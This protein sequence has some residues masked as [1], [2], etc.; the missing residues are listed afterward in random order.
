MKHTEE[1][2]IGGRKS[3][4]RKMVKKMKITNYGI[5]QQRFPKM[6]ALWLNLKLVLYLQSQSLTEM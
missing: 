4:T 1:K 5:I 3:N 2:T 6:W